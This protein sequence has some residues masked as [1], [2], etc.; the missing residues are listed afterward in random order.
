[1][2]KIK[3]IEVKQKGNKQ[4]VKVNYRQKEFNEVTKDFIEANIIKQSTQYMSTELSNAIDC[5]SPH[6]MWLTD[7]ASETISFKKATEYEKWF[8]NH[9]FKDD[10]RFQEV[11]I[12]KIVFFGEEKVDSVKIFGYKLAT[13]Y[14]K[15]H[16]CNLDTPQVALDRETS[17]YPLIVQLDEHIDNIVKLIE[18]W[19]FEGSTLTKEQQMTLFPS[20]SVSLESAEESLS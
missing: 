10:E 6:L 17:E 14:S 19:T 9:E 1:M 20:D 11:Y 16:K 2:Q 15:G 5:L 13:R 18:K 7:L 12:S 4:S 8:D 3:S